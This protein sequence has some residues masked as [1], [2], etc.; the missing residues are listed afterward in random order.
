MTRLMEG[1]FLG[2][3]LM[4]GVL[5][6]LLSLLPGAAIALP[7]GLFVV[8]IVIQRPLWIFYALVFSMGLHQF[9]IGGVRVTELLMPLTAGV[10]VSYWA[11][12][13][14]VPARTP[15]D[16]PVFILLS[17]GVLSLFNAEFLGESLVEF[18]RYV[19]TGVLL[20]IFSNL[21]TNRTILLNSLVAYLASC[22][23][24]VGSGLYGYMQLLRG[25]LKPPFLLF[26]TFFRLTGTFEDPNFCATFL[27]VGFFILLFVHKD[28]KDRMPAGTIPVL[29]ILL[30]AGIL[31][32]MSRAA[33][34]AAGAGLAMAW[35]L[36]P[37]M[38]TLLIAGFALAAINVVPMFFGINFIGEKFNAI[39]EDSGERTRVWEAGMR[40]IADKPLTGVGVGAYGPMYP[41]YKVKSEYRNKAMTSHN[42]L[43]GIW[44]EMG[45]L[46]LL[47]SSLIFLRFFQVAFRHARR[48]KDDLYHRVTMAALTAGMALFIQGF[49]LDM[50]TSRHMWY[51]FALGILQEMPG[52]KAR[53]EA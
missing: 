29:F 26:D 15:L 41:R 45:V 24:V 22:L 51:V 8:G 46:G 25:N 50:L 34:I 10:A 14:Q 32:T 5:A 3:W 11:R 7:V 23:F 37:N 21:L 27:M 38:R 9:S 19:Y 2:I 40:M 13:R 30:T 48:P 4:L 31:A 33:L 44:A 18:L 53:L 39:S 43:L 47:G 35:L 6:A 20:L 36:R 52:L 12:N 49:F 1:P 28:L 16:I 17:G 42:T